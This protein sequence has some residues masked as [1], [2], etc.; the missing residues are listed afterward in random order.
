MFTR[1]RYNGVLHLKYKLSIKQRGIVA[2]LG[3]NLKAKT[4]AK[5]RYRKNCSHKQDIDKKAYT[6]DLYL[7]KQDIHEL[8]HS[9]NHKSSTAAHAYLFPIY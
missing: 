5:R 3:E 2:P 7:Y 4:C 1:A 6:A 9:I 8:N